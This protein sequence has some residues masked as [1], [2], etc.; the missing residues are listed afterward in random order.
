MCEHWS[1]D[2]E[3]GEVL[4][5]NEERLA[6]QIAAINSAGTRSQDQRGQRLALR[7]VHPGAHGCV[8]AEFRVEDHLPPHMAQ[9]VF[10]PGN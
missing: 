1:I 5:A 3:L 8:R 9:G 2:T 4:Q 6:E 10:V 7:K